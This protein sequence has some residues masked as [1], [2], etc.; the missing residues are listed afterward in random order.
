[1]AI[2]DAALA[3][4]ELE[5]SIEQAREA[6]EHT[7]PMVQRAMHLRDRVED[8]LERIGAFAPADILHEGDPGA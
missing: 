7:A 5:A 6:A 4:R 1:M 8:T 2:D 3:A